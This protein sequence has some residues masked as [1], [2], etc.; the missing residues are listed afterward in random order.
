M[1]MDGSKEHNLG[2]FRKIFQEADYGINQTN[3]YSPCHFQAEETIR[4]L[5]KDAGRKMV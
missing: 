1:L 5:K 2:S 4:E 3:P